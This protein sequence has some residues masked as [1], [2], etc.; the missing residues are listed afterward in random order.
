MASPILRSLPF[1]AAALFSPA[2]L[3]DDKPVAAPPAAKPVPAAPAAAKPATAE[4]PAEPMIK[5]APGDK[6]PALKIEHWLKGAPVDQFEPG[7]IYVVEFWATWCGPCKVSMPHLSELQE[8]YQDYKVTFIGIS[9]E[10]LPTVKSFLDK[11]EWAAKTKYTVTTDP[12]RSAHKS[13]ME[14]ALQ[15]GIPTAFIVGKSGA[16]EWIG[17]PMGIDEP[18]EKIVKDQ[19]DLKSAR[20]TF[21]NAMKAQAARMQLEGDLRKAMSNGNW[22]ES[23]VL[24]EKMAEADPTMAAM[25]RGQRF[26]MML[27]HADPDRAYAYGRELLAKHGTDPQILN[28]VAWTIVDQEG[29]KRRDLDFALAAAIKAD[30]LTKGENAAILDTLARIYWDKGD[31][32]NAIATQKKAAANA[33]DNPMGEEIKATL[34][35]YEGG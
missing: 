8:R 5:L 25:V 33:P 21:E 30:E 18:L 20:A 11:P 29:V 19:W 34:R 6:A 16:V 13:Y 32:P 35:K 23:F 22:E 9:D 26:E 28:Q 2:I 17:H 3:A 10:G 31:K 24:L 15:R 27:V 14:A 4:K 7:N 1:V 12:D